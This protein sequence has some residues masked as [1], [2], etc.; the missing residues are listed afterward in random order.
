ML[1]ISKDLPVSIERCILS[2]KYTKVCIHRQ[3]KSPCK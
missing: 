2:V 3:D 1:S